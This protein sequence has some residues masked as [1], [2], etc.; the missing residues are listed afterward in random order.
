MSFF[1]HKW[2]EEGDSRRASPVVGRTVYRIVQEALTN[3]HKHAL[4][5]QVR[6][7]YDQAEMRLEV[8]NKPPTRPV[9]AGLIGTGSRMGLASL[10][11][12]VELVGGTLRAGPAPD[13]APRSSG[14]TSSPARRRWLR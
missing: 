3:A 14:S 5:A 2:V 7:R 8:R 13:G 12:R 11:R 4:G 1:G 10:R 9:E 6:V